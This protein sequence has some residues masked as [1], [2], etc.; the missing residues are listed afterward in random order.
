MKVRGDILRTYQSVHTWTGVIAGLFLFIAFWAGALTMFKPQIQQWASPPVALPTIRIDQM[1][2]L[3]EAAVAADKSV[4]KGFSL[5][6]NSREQ[7]K[8]PMV[9]FEKG[10]D[11]GL[12]LDAVEWHA[13]LDDSG[14]LLRQQVNPSMLGR[15][16]DQLHR[17]AG[18]PGEVGHDSLG[19]FFMGAISV[20]YFLALVSGVVILLPTLVKNLFAL[21]RKEKKRFWLDAHNLVGITSLPF[22]IIISLTAIVFAFHH[23]I[24][25]ALGAA[26]YPEGKKSPMASISLP[27]DSFDV[28]QLKLPS[29]FIAQLEALA[30]GYD[31]VEFNYMGLNSPRAIVRVGLDNPDAMLRGPIYDFAF[32]HAF[33]GD[34]LFTS[35]LPG[36]EEP[37]SSI[38]ASF[39]AL[40]FGSYGG[41]WGRWMYFFMGLGG[42]FLFY[43]GNL[44][45]L[46]KRRK[47]GLT[48]DA[49][50]NKSHR[51][52]AAT[53]VGVCL[54]SVIGVGA[55]MLGAKW[56]TLWLDNLNHAYL[57]I[58]YSF[59]LFSGVFAWVLGAGRSCIWLL[60]LAIAIALAIP[61]TSWLAGLVPSLGLWREPSMAT[62]GVELI[63]LIAAAGFYFLLKKTKQR[64]TTVDAT[65]VWAVA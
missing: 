8:S 5:T 51:W 62:L 44:L 50:K 2:E 35:G 11:R 56:L 32:F 58:Y 54:G 17:T 53:T 31:V 22:H 12:S 4:Q 52:L 13:S 16:I 37:W 48:A 36:D 47:S 6:L 29:D 42:A 19:V 34:L 61:C 15:L 46:E 9:W 14:E 20:L 23:E 18:I 64:I 38:V 10:S 25:D 63:S 7:H 57:W 3:V 40:H 39:F 60:K 21:R 45:W 49:T 33:T 55:S 59:F 27:K 41:F 26:V 43:T 1:D 65:S 30:P 28:E 24:Y